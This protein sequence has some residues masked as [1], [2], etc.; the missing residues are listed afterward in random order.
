VIKNG[1]SGNQGSR[2]R[3]GEKIEGN[4]YEAE[5]G[6]IDT[7]ASCIEVIAVPPPPVNVHGKRIVNSFLVIG[8]VKHCRQGEWNYGLLINCE[9]YKF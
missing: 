8:F 6:Q 3:S 9:I 5:G 1:K 7:A 4:T 2:G